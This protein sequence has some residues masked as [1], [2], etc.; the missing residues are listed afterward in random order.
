MF[1]MHFVTVTSKR[2][3]RRILKDGRSR[4]GRKNVEA[5]VK[6]GI[7]LFYMA[8]GGDGISLGAMSGLKNNSALKYLHEVSE[9][10]STH[11]APKWMVH[12]LLNSPGYMEKVRSRFHLRHG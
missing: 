3:S 4:N 7:A 6:V 5:R 1:K 10:I 8:H 11:I 12:G 9:V 2:G